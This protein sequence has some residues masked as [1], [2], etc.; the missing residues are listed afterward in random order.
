AARERP[1]S[2]T[3]RNMPINATEIRRRREA[4][5]PK[6]TPTRRTAQEKGDPRADCALPRSGTP[7]SWCG[8][9]SGR[10]PDA[11][12]FRANV[13]HG[14]NCQTGSERYGTSGARPETYGAQGQHLDFT[15]AERTTPRFMPRAKA[16]PATAVRRKAEAA[17]RP[18]FAF[19]AV[20]ARSYGGRL[21][22]P[23]T[24]CK[25]RAS[26]WARPRGPFA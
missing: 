15:P 18:T 16:A 22:A 26:K 24:A 17:R 1:R 23:R 6:G 25:F 21:T 19:A 20:M 8:F 4:F 12:S 13:R 7:P 11:I 3:K 5:Q 14:T 9:Q 2:D 10:R